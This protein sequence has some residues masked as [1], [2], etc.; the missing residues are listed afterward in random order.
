M[1]TKEK[2]S[3]QPKRPVYPAPQA[4]REEVSTLKQFNRYLMNPDMQSYLQTMLRSHK[5]QFVNNILAVVGNDPKLQGCTP[6]SLIYAGVKATALGLPLDPNLGHAY[7]IPYNNKKRYDEIQL[8]ADKPNEAPREVQVR[9]ECSVKEAQFQIG[10]KG[11]IQLAIR[12]GQFRTINVT[13]VRAGELGKKNLVTGEITFN[14]IPDRESQPVVGYLAYFALNNGFSKMLY[15]TIDEVK[16]HAKTYSQTYSSN[17][18]WV[19]E[20]SRWTTDFDVMARKT[21]LKLLLNRYAPLSVDIQ[22]VAQ[23]NDAI[24]VDQAVI[25]EQGN[26]DYVDGQ[27]RLEMPETSEEKDAAVENKKEQMRAKESNAQQLF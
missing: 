23:L 1:E 25:D 26:P 13:E 5:E 14:E 17:Q 11:F 2:Q 15:M 16:N 3:Q 20:A 22:G 21:V 10:Y 19:R 4:K 24:R 7:L 9:V 27:Q 18:A 12:T 6:Q 8:V